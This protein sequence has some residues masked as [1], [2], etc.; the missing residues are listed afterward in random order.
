SYGA[1]W[2]P[3]RIAQSLALGRDVGPPSIVEQKRIACE[4]VAAMLAHYGEYLGLRNARKHIGWYLETSQHA[5]AEIKSWR[6][7]LCTDENPE[8]VLAGLAEF[9]DSACELAA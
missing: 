1:P 8:R 6:R 9:Y 7:Q 4:H 2:L 5:A 3:G